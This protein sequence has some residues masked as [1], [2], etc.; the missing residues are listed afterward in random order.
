M[1]RK[2]LGK[3]KRIVALALTGAMIFGS[4][5]VYAKEQEQTAPV[6]EQQQVE[7][8]E[9]LSEM[10]DT[11][12]TTNLEDKNTK[13][14]DDSKEKR[15]SAST[16]IEK[17]ENSVSE[18][19]KPTANTDI[20][21]WMLQSDLLIDVDTK[22]GEIKLIQL[23]FYQGKESIGGTSQ[24]QPDI[25]MWGGGQG[26]LIFGEK[27]IQEMRE[28]LDSRGQ[29]LEDVTRLDIL[30]QFVKDG[31]QKDVTIQM[32]LR[33]LSSETGKPHFTDYVI[34]GDSM[35]GEK[36]LNLAAAMVQF[37]NAGTEIINFSDY[38]FKVRGIKN[39]ENV[40][41]N[42]SYI[43]SEPVEP[44][45]QP[46]YSS[47]RVN[48]TGVFPEDYTKDSAKFVVDVYAKNDPET[49]VY[50]TK[51]MTIYPYKIVMTNEGRVMKYN[52]PSHY[53]KYE[54]KVETDAHS[55]F[56][57]LVYGGSGDAT[58]I[59]EFGDDGKPVRTGIFVRS[60][61]PSSFMI[62]YEEGYV[63]GTAMLD[64]TDAGSVR[65]NEGNAN[66][67]FVDVH[68]PVTLKI[69]SATEVMLKGDFGLKFAVDPTEGNAST[70]SGM[71][72]L[73][74]TYEDNF[75]WLKRSYGANGEILAYETTVKIKDSILQNSPDLKMSIEGNAPRIYIP[76]PEGWDKEKIGVFYEYDSYSNAET[77]EI[78]EDGKYVIAYPEGFEGEFSKVTSKVGIFEKLDAT[79]AK[80]WE[81]TA[82][83]YINTMRYVNWMDP[84]KKTFNER[85]F[86]KT[87]GAND[88]AYMTYCME[89][90]KYVDNYR[91]GDTY[92]LEIPY[93][94]LV[95]DAAK[96]Y[97]NV[98]DLKQ[99]NMEGFFYYDAAKHAFISPEGGIGDAPPVVEVK[100]VDELGNK[101]YAIRFEFTDNIESPTYE[102][103]AT[104]VVE[105]NGAGNWRYI[106]F[107]KG[108]P[109]LA[110]IEPEKPDPEEPEDPKP[111][112][113]KPEK[114][115]E[116]PNQ[117]QELSEEV[118]E[119]VVEAVENAKKDSEVV[120]KMNGATV[121]P[122][123]TLEALKGKDVEL[124]LD[125]GAYSWTING[126]DVT[127]DTLKDI[128]L[129]V[130]VGSHAIPQKLVDKIADGNEAIQ[131]SLAHDGAFGFKAD[132]KLSVGAEHKGKN[133]KLYYYNEDGKLELVQSAKVAPD[134]T[135]VFTF[136][137]ASDYVI[138]L[139]K[140]AGT[141][142]TTPKTGD[143]SAIA[144]YVI[145]M[146]LAGGLVVFAERRR[147]CR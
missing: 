113:P 40:E 106:S 19:Y 52:D 84:E 129:K 90:E 111:E 130:T 101:T 43:S 122:K 20:K 14:T 1:Y 128:N 102:S 99:T 142:S 76:I 64:P 67:Y 144:L 70:L 66:I 15:K 97:K 114:P 79:V 27:Q 85:F 93:D 50:T 115:V 147:H 5:T 3:S 68:K 140:N 87:P 89:K 143:T 44:G 82:Y 47:S 132:L 29:K 54:V 35:I 12:S 146:I 123:E 39:C 42:I 38:E 118:V 32:P 4:M 75:D 116:N 57:G 45:Q 131:I 24:I 56:E 71:E 69:T 65:Q 60:G 138:V 124:V 61:Y 34:A 74:K 95:K 53:S 110:P 78:T 48:I 17:S 109:E 108:Y 37:G 55:K 136:E 112:D 134:G 107:L 7:S 139:E 46:E 41:L 72:M 6:A 25:E 92:N 88:A 133:A 63:Y 51:E 103:E 91:V 31:V 59:F 36:E 141:T 135:V 49:L 96:Y 127:A 80:D 105:D 83:N 126:K 145:L 137:H 23:D 16:E 77:A 2:F 98:P 100:K 117:G 21:E 119:Q 58:E 81:T 86:E 18:E 26:Q 28:M 9:A 11:Q 94:V 10:E 121:V 22:G 30:I 73:V 33:H 8:E 62:S 120:V 13:P 104:L 125:M